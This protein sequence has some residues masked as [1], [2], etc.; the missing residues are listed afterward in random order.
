MGI[1]KMNH[2]TLV[3]LAREKDAVLRALS[4][5]GAVEIRENQEQAEAW[6]AKQQE[7]RGRVVEATEQRQLLEQMI[8]V[9]RDLLPYKK[10]MFTLKRSISMSDFLSYDDEK[11]RTEVLGWASALKEN[12]RQYQEAQAKK[13]AAQLQ[14]DVLL[15]W[16]EALAGADP[17][18]T[19]RIHRWLGR[20]ASPDQ[21]KYLE[22]GLKE[23]AP[24][25]VVH[26]L[27]KPEANSPVYVLL[28]APSSEGE[29]PWQAAQ[30]RGFRPLQQKA[31]KLTPEQEADECR[32]TI[33][34]IEEKM[35]T[36]QT[37]AKELARHVAAYEELADYLAV[38]IERLDNSSR[39]LSSNRLFALEG[40]IPAYLAQGTQKGL[41]ESFCVSL[42]M[43][44]ADRAEDYPI[45]LN[46]NKLTKPYEAVTDMFSLPMAAEVDP[47]P[48]VAPTYCLFFGM[49]FSDIAY[50]ILF[51]IITGLLVWKVKVQGNFRKMCQVFFQC[52]LSSIVWGA[53]FGGFFGNMVSDVFKPLW[54]DPMQAPTKLMIWSIIF[55]TIHIF[56]GLGVKMHV[57]IATNNVKEALVDVLPW[58]FI[59]LGL[60]M[61][62]GGYATGMGLLTSIGTYLAIFGAI[63]ILIFAGRPSK[64]P[65]VRLF[66]GIG[67]LYS[68]TGYFSD[69][70]SYT[71]ILALCL[72][73]SVIAMVVNLLAKLPGDG[74]VGIIFFIIVA[75]L[76]HTLNFALSALSAYVHTTRLH[77]VE[78][79]GKFFEGGGRAFAPL[80]YH[81]KYVLVDLPE[82]PKPESESLRKRFAR[83]RQAEE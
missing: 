13:A 25:A 45:L 39:V 60:G 71:R 78:Y 80:A 14:L 11:Y 8:P 69:I 81:T 53:L 79:F 55:G 27:L 70:M 66:K 22:E 26:A 9:S 10:P 16:Q 67:S 7:E 74:F 36:L 54:F 17:K 29:A 61:L 34:E 63:I 41:E 4:K 37:E 62:G 52:G 73:T 1:V 50:G 12:R 40:Y 32:E 43:R 59:I 38:Q 33:K 46:N 6:E 3:G 15:P 30:Q 65:L 18:S 56:I 57:L 5:L 77:Y 28:A 35:E 2:L 72:S 83:F 31:A 49:M 44:P 20:V 64:N 51:C 76:G 42:Q 82:G 68:V 47:V 23:S 75:I 58:F 21:F 19:K 24:T 48:S